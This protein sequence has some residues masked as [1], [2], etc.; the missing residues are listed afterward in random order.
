MS[1]SN[2]RNVVVDKSKFP[3]PLESARNWEE[4]EAVVRIE[5][6]KDHGGW[7]EGG[8]RCGWVGASAEG[9]AGKRGP[10]TVGMGE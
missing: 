10:G 8:V 4:A 5:L 3:A 1:W 9:L 6:S 2:T 7:Q